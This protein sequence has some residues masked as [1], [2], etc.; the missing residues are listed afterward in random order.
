MAGAAAVNATRSRSS[1]V[2]LGSMGI[3]A[4]HCREG[5]SAKLFVGVLYSTPPGWF[6][7][8][9]WGLFHPPARGAEPVAGDL[10]LEVLPVDAR[11]RSRPGDVPAGLAELVLEIRLL[12][13][14]LGLLERQVQPRRRGRRL[15]RSPFQ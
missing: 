13:P 3:G 11:V 4:I 7:P 1:E 9:R 8:T 2:D 5:A 10:P 6:H 15:R 12:E 14:A